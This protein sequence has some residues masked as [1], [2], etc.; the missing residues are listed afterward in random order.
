MKRPRSKSVTRLT[1][2]AERLVSLALGL[3][4]SGSLTEDHYWEAQLGKLVAHLLESGHENSINVA[5]DHLLQAQSNAYETLI[6]QVESLTESATLEHQ[7]KP[8]DVLLIAAP[9][10]AWSKYAIAS[11]PLHA[12]AALSLATHLQAHVM[13]AGTRLA[14]SP[15]LYSIDQLPR[16]FTEVSKLTSK[17]GEAALQGAAPKID[18]QRMPE[19]APLLADARFLIAAVVAPQGEA[20]F[21]WQQLGSVQHAGRTHCLEQW[22]AQGRPNLAPLLQGC[23]F[24]CMLPEA[25]YVSCRESER[26]VRPYSIRA[27]VAFLESALKVNPDHLCAIIAG[28]GAE[29]IDE[30]RVSLGVRGK[31]DEVAHGIVWPL[32]GREDESTAPTPLEDI[33]TQ[34]RE[35][36]ITDLEELQGIHSPEFCEDCGAPLFPTADGEIVHPGLPDE[37]DAPTAH[38]H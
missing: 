6:D 23:V 25:Y 1:P 35:C 24:E 26:S 10:V 5:L 4:A 20:L 11:G 16:H 15:Y 14:L 19:T 12:D 34:L 18:L 22:V 30:Y 9:I 2:D 37:V 32:Y 27:A 17:L 31:V 36:G 13:A 38:F 29:R 28:F 33:R 8:W 21:R 3:A 7:G